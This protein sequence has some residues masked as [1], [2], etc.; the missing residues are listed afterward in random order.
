MGAT[1]LL[2]HNSYQKGWD[3]VFGSKGGKFQK[4]W[5]RVFGSRAKNPKPYA[6]HRPKHS[7]KWLKQLWDRDA[8]GKGYVID[9]NSKKKLTWD[10]SKLRRGQWDAGHTPDH[11]YEYLHKRYMD[12][13]ISKKQFLKEFRNMDNYRFEGSLENQGHYYE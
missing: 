10:S 4:G 5:D 1:G 6:K 2:V 3:R 7:K 8:Q 9:P 13:K 11:K 12:G